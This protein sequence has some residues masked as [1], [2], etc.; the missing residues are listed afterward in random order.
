MKIT[1]ESDPKGNLDMVNQHPS[2]KIQQHPKERAYN[3]H[4]ST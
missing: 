3:Q 1:P 4:H 2:R